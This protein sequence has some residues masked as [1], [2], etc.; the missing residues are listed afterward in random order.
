ML[1]LGNKINYNNL[2][3]SNNKAKNEKSEWII[4]NCQNSNESNN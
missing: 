1:I 2:N 3:I 4:G